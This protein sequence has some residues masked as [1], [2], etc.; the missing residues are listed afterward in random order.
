MVESGVRT[1]RRFAERGRFGS[2][3]GIEGGLLNIAAAGPKADAAG[4]VR[5]GFAGNDVRAGT[6][7]SAAAGEAR[8]GEI[9]TAPE[10]M[11]RAGLA[12]ETRPELIQDAV[13]RSED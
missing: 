4:F 8:D 11:Y 10:K 9:E 5:V 2:Y 13:H 7:R 12:D 6:L 3:I 1:D